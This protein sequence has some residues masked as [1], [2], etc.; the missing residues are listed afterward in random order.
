[1]DL[2]VIR[3]FIAVAEAGSLTQA[4]LRVHVAQ[5]A[6]TRQLRQLEA[7]LG[8]TLFNR[9]GRG[10]TLTVAGRRFLPMARDLTMRAADLRSRAASLRTGEVQ[11][12]GLVA[13]M[14]TIADWIAPYLATVPLEHPTIAV[15][16]DAPEL[17]MSALSRGADFV[18]G[19]TVPTHDVT[20]VLIA[21]MPLYAYVRSEHEWAVRERIA[22]RDLTRETLLVPTPEHWAR[23]LLDQAAQQLHLSYSRIVECRVPQ[24]AQAFAAAGRGIAVV[25]D[26]PRFG[27]HPLLVEGALGLIRLPLYAAWERG[28]YADTAMRD[29]VRRMSDYCVHRYGSVV[30]GDGA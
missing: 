1:M 11:H 12:L 18:I 7:E 15:V 4:A 24:V 21:H 19:S 2:R 17:V 23:T 29:V 8:L 20:T 22:L 25:T 6:L 28:H 26:D 30:V 9:S 27:L 13:P 16:D 5:P 14:V 10:L 3:Y